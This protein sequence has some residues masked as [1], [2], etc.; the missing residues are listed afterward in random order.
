MREAL[1]SWF[2]LLLLSSFVYAGE[3]RDDFEDGNANGWNEVMGDWEVQEGSYAQ[4]G[5]G[6]NL[7]G[8]P[9]TIIESPWDFTDGTIEVT[10]TFDK[11]SNDDEIPAILYRLIDD[12][13]GYAF[14]VQ[15]NNLEMGR[16]VAGQYNSIRGDAFPIDTSKPF[17]I[18]IE[19]EGMFTKAYYNDVVK[20]RVGDLEETFKKGKVGLAVFDANKPIYFDDF[21]ISGA[22]IFPFPPLTQ[23]V[24]PAGKLASA[25]GKIKFQ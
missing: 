22:G 15:S 18:K 16:F 21:V 1:I 23:N 8:V 12:D 17:K 2:C 25:W 6:M 20:I 4:L 3:C 13:N 10:M 19:V 7:M 14:R 24:D 5:A 11:K 9:R